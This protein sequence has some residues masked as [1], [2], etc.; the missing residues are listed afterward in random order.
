MLPPLTLRIGGRGGTLF[1][2][3][4]LAALFALFV[5]W[6]RHFRIGTHMRAAASLGALGLYIAACLPSTLNATDLPRHGYGLVLFTLAWLLLYAITAWR[7]SRPLLD[8]VIRLSPL[9]FVILAL[10]VLRTAWTNDLLAGGRQKMESAYGGSNFLASMLLLG[11]F[12]PLA[13][14]V[15]GHTVRERGAALLAF[16]VITAAT[17]ATGSRLAMGLLPLGCLFTIVV[18][19][20]R[21]LS[22]RRLALIGLVLAVVAL[23]LTPYLGS[24]AAH[25][26][27]RDP[28]TQRNLIARLVICEHYW[29][30]FRAHPWIGGGLLNGRA[31]PVLAFAGEGTTPG[32]G[33]NVDAHNW[34]LQALAD[35]GVLGALAFV[36]FLAAAGRTFLSG[37]RCEHRW[38]ASSAGFLV[39]FV[40]VVLHGLLEPNFHGKPFI[41]LFVAVLGLAEQVQ[42]TS[43]LKR[44]ALAVVPSKLYEVMSMKSSG[45]WTTRRR[46]QTVALALA[47]LLGPAGARA[48]DLPGA[49]ELET[50]AFTPGAFSQ[51]KELAGIGAGGEEPATERTPELYAPPPAARVEQP[52]PARPD[53]VPARR[54]RPPHA[55]DAPDRTQFAALEPFGHDVFREGTG[56]FQILDEVPVPADYRLGPG[57]QLVINVWG[58]VDKTYELLID[59]EGKIFLPEAG[60]VVVWGLDLPAATARVRSQLASVYSDFKVNLMMGRV[61]SIRVYVY[62][63]AE[64]TGSYTVSSLST[65]MNVLHQAGGPTDRGSMR[66]VRVLRD[67]KLFQTV[68]LYQV[69]L[70]GEGEPDLTLGSN[71]AI[72]IPV[73]GPRVGVAGQ[74]NRPAIYELL[75]GETVADAI[76]LAGGPGP[77][78]Y[79][80]RVSVDRVTGGNGRSVFD[81]DLADSTEAATP[82]GDGDR[83]TLYTADEVRE[84][85]VRLEGWVKYGG[86][87]GYKPGLRISDLLRGGEALRPESYLPRAVI[88]RRLPDG[89]SRL[90]P[91]DLSAALGPDLRRGA[92]PEG[93][94][95]LAG[96]PDHLG[97]PPATDPP[98]YGA[99]G[100]GAADPLLE[101]RDVVHIYSAKDVAWLHYVTIDG[102]VKKPGR[103]EL[104]RDMRVSDLLFEASGLTPESDLSAELVRRYPDGRSQIVAV[105]LRRLLV[106]GDSTADLVLQKDDALLVRRLPD[107]LETESVMIEGEV[108]F[109]GRYSLA[110]RD[111]LLSEVLRRA[112]GPTDQAFLPGALFTRESIAADVSRQNVASV[113]M[114]FRSDSATGATMRDAPWLSDVAPELL[115]TNRMTIQL[116][117]LWKERSRRYDVPLR[118]GDRL[119]IPRQPS[120][121]T[122]MGN[123]AAAGSVQFIP[124]KTV[125][126]YLDRAGDVGPD[127]QGRGIRVVRAN[128]EVAKC[129]KGTEVRV[130]D[131]IVVPPRGRSSSAWRWIREGLLLAGATATVLLLINQ[132]D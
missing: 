64:Q 52:A 73:V 55:D 97:V 10:I 60:A 18:S 27:F 25:G 23:A 119:F 21:H 92:R 65:L 91:V 40:I 13:V 44:P 121:V 98:S 22:F 122:V 78:A 118:D 103:Y 109:P 47:V 29:S 2:L 120:A 42:R 72:F 5:L 93:P 43:R 19:Q 51:M 127:G 38:W 94:A 66:R 74:V 70:H 79:H 117:R 20:R 88:R 26:R 130:G 48:D 30:L 31:S 49:M 125:G 90:I 76:A 114:S 108:R 96:D 41:Y 110:R 3:E 39:G 46:G 82:I 83:V 129:G 53:G 9:P 113:F 81:L 68:D 24:L 89:S 1:A 50:E 14:A 8:E 102:Q 132:I 86:V 112:G 57:D 15:G 100:A 95:L 54:S 105:D 34:L 115:P 99:S 67:G 7:P 45:A 107:R 59:R 63:E 84:D 17:V 16:A 62:G 56:S 33:A 37:V 6:R 111:E 85:V 69:L 71:D 124:G 58:R 128:G 123:V 12:V 11:A 75:G 77:E 131:S 126:Y 116:D 101:P 80:H 35:S 28:L 104:A 61:R 32:W 36:V 87:Y 106:E 4:P